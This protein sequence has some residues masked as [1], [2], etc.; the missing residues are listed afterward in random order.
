MQMTDGLMGAF[1]A[2]DHTDEKGIICGKVLGNLEID[3]IKVEKTGADSACKIPPIY[4]DNPD[5]DKS[6]CWY[7]FN[8]NKR[9]IIR[10]LENIGLPTRF[11]RRRYLKEKV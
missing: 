5:S 1:R 7:S 11:D 10:N 6:L 3:I 8:T 9:S 2:L 4:L